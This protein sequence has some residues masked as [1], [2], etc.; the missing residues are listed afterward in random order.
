MPTT[1]RKTF[2]DRLHDKDEPVALA[3]IAHNSAYI[4]LHHEPS[5]PYSASSTQGGATDAEIQDTID[6]ARWLG[7][8]LVDWRSAE[9][10]D[11]VEAA[12]RGPMPAIDPERAEQPNRGG[13][14]HDPRLKGYGSFQY[15]ALP[16][17]LDIV[18]AFGATVIRP[19]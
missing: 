12:C 19:A 10:S 18:E 1:T 6:A 8:A 11:A 5:A 3:I 15:A 17:Y 16:D 7:V 9:H 13:I 4:T 14:G 2:A